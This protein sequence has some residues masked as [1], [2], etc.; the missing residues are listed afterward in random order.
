MEASVN[1]TIKNE[2]KAARKYAEGR[3][4][5]IDVKNETVIA[6]IKQLID[7]KMSY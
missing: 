1:E 5:S 2:L 4:I 3:G 7:I 6:D